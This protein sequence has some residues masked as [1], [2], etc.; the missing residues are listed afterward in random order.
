MSF[1]FVYE[2]CRYSKTHA[3]VNRFVTINVYTGVFDI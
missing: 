2:E 1:W 3:F